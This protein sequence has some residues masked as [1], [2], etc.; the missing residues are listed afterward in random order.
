MEG[1]T[2]R[3]EKEDI[4]GK[5]RSSTN[6]REKSRGRNELGPPVTAKIKTVG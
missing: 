4:S 5:L 1:I 3:E 6:Q 2:K